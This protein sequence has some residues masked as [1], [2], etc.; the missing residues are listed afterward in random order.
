VCNEVV[1]GD[2][3]IRGYEFA[4]DQ[5]VQLTEAELQSLEAESSNNIELKEFI[6]LS[7][8]DPVYFE[9][10]YYL[11]AGEGGEKPYRLLADALAKTDRGAIAQLLTRGKKQLVLI[12][13]HENGLIMHSLYYANEVRNFGEIAKA[14]N[15]KLSDA[16]VELGANLIENMSDGFN[17]ENYR[18]EYRERVQAMLDEKSKGGEITVAAPEAPARAQIID[19]MQALKQSIEKAKPKEKAAPARRKRKTAALDS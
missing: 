4:K 12:R 10:A 19:L 17:P 7:K 3:R 15:M 14:E 11:G 18:D 9:S 8:I 16:E 1:Q 6:P 5:Y 13:P 2:D